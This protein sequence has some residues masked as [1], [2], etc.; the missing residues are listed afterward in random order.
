MKVIVTGASGLVGRA[1]VSDVSARNEIVHGYDHASLDI[2]DELAVNDALQTIRPDVVINC[3]AFT[4]VD[5]C[6]TDHEH[7]LAVNARGPE[8]LALACRAV[9]SLLVTISTDYIFDGRKDG[10]YTQE[11]EPNPISFY[12]RSKLE[13]ERLAQ[14]AHNRTI[15][16]RTGYIFGPG[17]KNFLS[18]VIRRGRSGERLRAVADMFGTPTFADDLAARIYDLVRLD[19]P[20]VYHVVNGG[21]GA[22]FA[23]FAQIAAEIAGFSP[24]LLERTSIESL[25]LPAQ[26]PRNSRLRC[27]ASPRLDL[28]PL[29]SWQDGLARF[30]AKSS[31][32]V[33]AAN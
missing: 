25:R 5:R 30:W 16:I 3:A 8:R 33:T 20:D 7:A 6:E 21:D 22:S 4:D 28:D 14:K 1:M 23:D 19:Q 26:R 10:F 12:G 18:N 15:V 9:N 2:T 11:D 13:G 27:L 17:G 31:A 32:A 24:E 29:P